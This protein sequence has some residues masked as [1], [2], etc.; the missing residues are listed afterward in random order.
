MNLFWPLAL[1]ANLI[2]VSGILFL[3]ACAQRAPHP[4]SIQ[5]LENAICVRE[6]L[7]DK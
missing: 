3:S 5:G 7:C 6:R 1:C 4:I 2:A